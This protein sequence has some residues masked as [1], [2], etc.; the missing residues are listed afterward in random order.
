MSDEAAVSILVIEDEVAHARLIQRSL[1]SRHDR[2][3]THTV[4]TL[5]EA[6][7]FLAEH[8][9]DLLLV[10]MRLPDGEGIDLL[11][12]DDDGEAAFPVVI[13]TSYGDEGAAV[14]AMRAG[15]LDYVVK[16]DV[17]FLEMPHIIQRALREWEHLTERRRAEEL[18]R[19]ERALFQKY[20][21][22]VA[23]VLVVIGPDERV[24][25]VNRKGSQLLGYEEEEIVGRN[26]FDQFVPAHVRE[27]VR[28]GF[29][30]LMS[31]H[32]K[33]IEYYEN[34]VLTRDGEERLIA[35]QNTLLT[36][37]TGAVVATIS[38]GE[39][40]TER[41]KA[42]EE[43]LRHEQEFRALAENSPDAVMRF[44]RD[45][46]YLYANPAFCDLLDISQEELI[47]KTKSEVGLPPDHVRLF[48]GALRHVFSTGDEETIEYSLDTAR[49]GEEYFETRVVPEFDEGGTVKSA[50]A[51][52]RNI[53][54]R[55]R[56]EEARHQAH[57][58][59]LDLDKEKD[60]RE[61]KSR[62]VS[63]VTHE[64]RNPLSAIKF[65]A[66]MLRPRDIPADST[67]IGEEFDKILRN[68]DYMTLLLEDILLAGEIEAGT[69][70]LHPVERDLGEFCHHTFHNLKPIFGKRHELIYRGIEQPLS[71]EFDEKLMRQVISN[72][73][74][75]AVKY[76]DAGSHVW[77]ELQSNSRQVR[78]QVRDE[79]IGIPDED[80][81]RLFATFQRASNVGPRKGTGLGLAIVRQA[82]EMH[83]GSISFTS[84][85]NQGTTFTVTLPRELPDD[86]GAWAAGD[87]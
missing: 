19:N 18:L 2:L 37:E 28:A 20:L 31:G 59:R 25:L 21:E 1:A 39:D 82:V 8:S 4:T 77:F 33:P 58:L 76:S 40:I 26:W 69:L 70:R 36:D 38:S 54:E 62:F 61:A 23:V 50:L 64:F 7:Q 71:M 14:E 63:M 10:D 84:R 42:E 24:S 22:V 68:V 3:Q 32:L 65:S 46:R 53:T 87:R 17:T 74:S 30:I 12:G 51:I 45:Y 81:S 35:W 43:I 57:L 9:P 52:S 29:H 80:Q 48:E 85:L 34:P 5:A 79:G 83:G 55:V 86:S 60:L 27:T 66:S 15:A 44:D 49:Y 47:G 67:W 73:I 41:R 11:P 72:L 13:M 16:S 56:G 75:N 6:R 78:M